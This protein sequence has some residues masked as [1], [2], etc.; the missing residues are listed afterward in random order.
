MLATVLK[1]TFIQ[2]NKRCLRSKYF[3]GELKIVGLKHPVK[4]YRDEAHVPHIF[5]KTDE[6]LMFAQGWIHAQDRLWQMEMNRR[7]AM[8]RLSEAFGNDALDTDRLIR[9]LG[10]NRLS[11]NDWENTSEEMK[12]LLEK[13]ADGV[14]AYIENGKLPIEF[15]LTGIKP[16]AWQPIHTI[17][18]G[19]VMSWTL[20]HGW[21]GTLTRQ[22]II[23][24]VGVEKASE[25][26]IY[27]PEDNPVE[28]PNGLEVNELAM[29]DML[30][31][32]EGPYLGKD[33]E[34]GGRG[35]N[36]W[37]INGDKTDSGRPILCND[38][39]LVLTT[40]GVWYLNHL[41]SEEGLHV[42]GAS[43]PGV[44]GVMLG[45]NEKC[46]WGITLAF[47][48]VED[49]FVEKLCVDNPNSYEYCGEKL[50][51]K[52]IEEEILIKGAEPHNEKVMYSKHGPIIGK[53]VRNKNLT[54]SLS[55]KS[56]EPL[57]LP[58]AI[59]KMNTS[60]SVEDFSHAVDEILAPQLNIAY[61]DTDGNIG[62]FISGRV[63]I[64]KSGNGQLPV[65]GWTDEY[66]WIGEIPLKD[67]PKSVNPNQGYLISCNHKIVADDFPHY[68][69][70]SF[71]NGFRAKRIQQ[72]FESKTK[73]SIEDCKQLHDD[74]YSIPAEIF[75]NG[76][77]TGL[78]TA[79]P[80]VQKI[81]DILMDWDF[82]LLPST[83]AATV[84]QVL[85]YKL[86]REIVEKDLGEE[87][88]NKYMGEGEHPLLL[89]TSELLGH[90][91][92]AI[93]NMF[94]NSDSKWL[95]SSKEILSVLEKSMLE[96]C[97]WLEENMGYEYDDWQWGKIHH[98][99]FRHGMSI[100][101]PLDKIFNVGP[102]EIGGDTDTVCQTAYNPNAPYHATEWCPS[103]RLIMD[104]GEWDNSLI[105]S[106][107]GQSGV[108]GSKHYDDMADLWSKGDYINMLWSEDKIKNSSV[109]TFELKP[110]E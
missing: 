8:G 106:P 51:F 65:P 94:Q 75:I 104:V 9:T 47:T 80:K 14:N 41:K 2:Y 39:H 54:I 66:E 20:S 40:P 110:E 53:V 76:M 46:A 3:D 78:R 77:I 32:M 36:A 59:Y 97:K 82:Y 50:N 68:L 34:G 52:I 49:I 60:D 83:S 56:L 37:T 61:A 79:K 102:F 35:S 12:V 109:S 38:T 93:F 26:N 81:L 15:A 73:I 92:Q 19:R 30:K 42:S 88:T 43:L 99:Q 4:I 27:Y 48:D 25:L 101:S 100:K 29:A 96:T 57:K 67:M 90:T 63:P 89:P 18:W 86:V 98:V 91:T 24:K 95:S 105:V 45:H 31:S 108:L 1:W 55:S 22:E 16:E 69:G 17:G 64:R 85:M 7:V 58:E 62:L 33:F 103:I 74:V 70:N 71:M 44:N 84:Y 107:P 6:D 21:S 87:L 5:A 10:F 72:I 23:E 13:Y 28:L 11:K